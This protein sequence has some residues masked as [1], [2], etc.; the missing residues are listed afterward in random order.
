[1]QKSAGPIP[2]SYWLVDGELLAGGYPGS[3]DTSTARMKLQAILAAGVRSFIDLTEPHELTAYDE[4]LEDIAREMN[5]EVSYERISIRDLGIPPR[6]VMD[7]ILATIRSQIAAGSTVYVHCWGGVGRTGTVVGC[8]LVEEG[9]PCDEVFERIR[10]LRAHT[11]EA[12]KRSPETADQRAFVRG[13]RR[14]NA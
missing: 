5:V 2:N 6:E 8:W 12:W 4:L 7:A 14:R 3:S 13:W 1:M 11:P 10:A 9:Q